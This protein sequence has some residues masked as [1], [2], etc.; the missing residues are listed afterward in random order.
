M[1]VS[2][3]SVVILFIFL[4]T[5]TIEI[6]RSFTRG[7]KRG[8]LSLGNVIL[9][10]ICAI[11]LSPLLARLIVG[12]LFSIIVS[13]IPG[14]N[15]LIEG[16]PSYDLLIRMAAG[17]IL[18]SV[19]FVFVFF[20]IRGVFASIIS[21][22]LKAT[23]VEEN[24]ESS[25]SGNVADADVDEDD[26]EGRLFKDRKS[27]GVLKVV[28]GFFS[29]VIITTAITAPLMGLLNL[30][31]DA[32]GMV[33]DGIPNLW[34]NA[35]NVQTEIDKIRGYSKDLAGNVFYEVGGKYIFRATAK[36]TI[37]GKG[38]YL[39]NEVEALQLVFTDFLD[40]YPILQNPKNATVDDIESLRNLSNDIQKVNACHG[41]LGDYF[42]DCSEAWLN[43]KLYLMMRR[44]SLHSST[45]PI[46]NEIL[47]VCSNSNEDNVRENV[48]SILNIC[49]LVLESGLTEINTNDYM[50]LANLIEY[51]DIIEKLQAEL[52]KN[53]NMAHINVSE[54]AMNAL[55][56]ALGGSSYTSSEY[57][58]F[59]KD[60]TD[61]MISVQNRGYGSKEE[62]ASVLTSYTKKYLSDLGVS[63][64][65]SVLSSA[66]E[67]I[68]DRMESGDVAITEEDV[69]EMFKK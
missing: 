33:E 24:S 45:D 26:R 52:S 19:I 60:M 59:I 11:I 54:M 16:Y 28:I 27:E 10:L 49:I 31:D 18:S 56:N 69:R 8:A 29:A 57:S 46:V 32:I 36:G 2:L 48:V 67:N 14:Y 47:V 65:E 6:Y 5:A 53:P 43:G 37:Y 40:A 58:T 63:V 55:I 23:A 50:A 62:K 13:N 17:A 7:S 44:P 15:N 25:G 66:V 39:V 68:V 64:P 21:M 1:T 61:A 4:T 41:V 51:T 42:S 20:V 38:V 30:T 12:G 34:D 3:F 22:K 9:S 35:K